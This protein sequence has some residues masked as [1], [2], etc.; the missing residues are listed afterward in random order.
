VTN[1][2]ENFTSRHIL[3]FKQ[4]RGQNIVLE[5]LNLDQHGKQ[6]FDHIIRG[7]ANALWRHLP[8][9]PFDNYECYSAKMESLVQDHGWVPMA[10]ISPD[11][12]TAIGMASFL[13]IRPEHGSAE[14]G[15]VIFSKKLQRTRGAT[16]AM[17][18]MA[19]H[20]FSE[21]G[22]RR[23]EWKCDVNNRASRNTALRLGFIFEG[24][25]RNH[26]IQ[27]GK[28]RDT[29]W[30]SIIDSEWQH[31]CRIIQDWL[32]AKNFDAEGKQHISLSDMMVRQ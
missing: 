26:M 21:L 4:L 3:G 12:K 15:G 17:F 28:S 14:I 10:I 29:A 2:L 30:F 18:L 19:N 16:E 22:Y 11:S 20:V 27:K 1:G 25:F 8:I 13:R 24:I 32:A 23:Y 6:L 31:H 5:P 7:D 9:G